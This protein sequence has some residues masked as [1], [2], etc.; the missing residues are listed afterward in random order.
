ME[1][2][3]TLKYFEYIIRLYGRL[4]AVYGV[5]EIACRVRH[6]FVAFF[7]SPI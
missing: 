2:L 5:R 7:S 6:K 1:L 3:F 4:T